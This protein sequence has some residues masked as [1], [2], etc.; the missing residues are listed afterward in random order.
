MPS[1]QVPRGP[2]VLGY[3]RLALYEYALL[4]AGTAA[5]EKAAL[6]AFAQVKDGA[7][8]RIWRALPRKE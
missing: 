5:V 6:G 2:R 1:P 3:P 4:L 8:R 7:R